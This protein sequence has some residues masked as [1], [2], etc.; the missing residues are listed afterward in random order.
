M[1]YC[2]PRDDDKDAMSV[3]VAVMV[4]MSSPPTSDSVRDEE[5]K[6]KKLWQLVAR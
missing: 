1:F 6:L 5:M 4:S 3:S 2:P